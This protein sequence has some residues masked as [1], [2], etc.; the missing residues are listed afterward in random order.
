[1]AGRRIERATIERRS[2]SPHGEGRKA[3][4]L[5]IGGIADRAARLRSAA[6]GLEG[7]V[8][9]LEEFARRDAEQ[10]IED[11]DKVVAGLA[12]MLAAEGVG[13]IEWV[14]KLTSAHDK[15]GAIDG[16]ITFQIHRISPFGE[17]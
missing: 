4:R 9:V 8:D 15:T 1:M 11:L 10:A 7:H 16:P 12:A 3:L 14:G 6:V 2:A 13:E 5:R 17:G